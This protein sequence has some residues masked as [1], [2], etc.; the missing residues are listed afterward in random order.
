M[1]R[2]QLADGKHF[3]DL[4]E[5][6]NHQDDPC[7]KPILDLTQLT[8]D[9][10]GRF[11]RTTGM[12]YRILKDGRPAGLCWIEVCGRVL[13]LH[14]LIL[15]SIFQ[16]QGIGAQTLAWL[17]ETFCDEID[18]IEL[19]VHASNMRAR[20]LYQHSG[21]VASAAP[22]RSGF[23]TMRKTLRNPNESIREGDPVFCVAETTD[24]LPVRR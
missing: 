1:I 4:L 17:E 15:R 9:Q 12:V 6:I 22:D 21:Y 18:A 3:D 13:R 5:I 20:S 23:Y 16:G 19:I 11:F 7:L 14:G 8:W 10:F 24:R 2:Y